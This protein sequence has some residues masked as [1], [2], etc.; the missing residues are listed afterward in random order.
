MRITTQLTLIALGCLALK[1]K[2][3]TDAFL[4]FI[5]GRMLQ[6]TGQ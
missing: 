3:S 6:A 2:A 4:N 5:D 1:S